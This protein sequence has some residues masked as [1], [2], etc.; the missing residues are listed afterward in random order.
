MGL[1][2]V[3]SGVGFYNYVLI[4][5]SLLMAC[6]TGNVVNEVE[7]QEV[8]TQHTHNLSKLDTQTG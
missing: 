7:H 4:L 5:I 3:M 1:L 6:G 2:C 8:L